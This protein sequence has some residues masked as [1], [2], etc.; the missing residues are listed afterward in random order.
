MYY[1]L[2]MLIIVLFI[3]LYHLIKQYN[4]Q[5]GLTCNYVFKRV[6]PVILFFINF[7]YRDEII[8]YIKNL[9]NNNIKNSEYVV[10]TTSYITCLSTT[11]KVGIVCGSIV[12]VY[13]IYSC[14]RAY[15]RTYI[16]TNFDE[17][18]VIYKYNEKFLKQAGI[19]ENMPILNYL[20]QSFRKKYMLEQEYDKVF[21]TLLDFDFIIF[22]KLAN[23]NFYLCGNL[24]YSLIC[25]LQTQVLNKSLSK[26]TL[27]VFV[28]VIN[29]VF[30]AYGFD[31]IDPS[32]ILNMEYSFEL[33]KMVY[34]RIY[35]LN[36]IAYKMLNVYVAL[37]E[38]PEAKKEYEKFLND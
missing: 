31:L 37:K 19:Q 20:Q 2:Y 28:Y 16:I 35:E 4:T 15:T 12:A 14:Y 6:I 32:M 10:T 17:N 22:R 38:N 30:A 27:S 9:F 36:Y 7:G 8:F 5:K 13:L 21:K 11:Q 33:K 26:S 18:N 23:Q 25:D 3:F 29:T 34:S 1:Q 24:N